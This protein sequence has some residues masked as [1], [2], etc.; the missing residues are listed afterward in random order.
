MH[1]YI[2]TLLQVIVWYDTWYD[3][4]WHDMIYMIWYDTIDMIRYDICMMYDMIRYDIYFVN[5]NW[6]D[7][8]WQQ[9][10]THLHK[11]NKQNNAMKQ[12]TQNMHKNRVPKHNNKLLKER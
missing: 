6:V 8:R 9:Y 2:L 10:G 5:C 4:I 3:K 7:T 11:N 12:N 1:K